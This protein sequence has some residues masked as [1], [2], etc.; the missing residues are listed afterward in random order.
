MVQFLNLKENKIVQY[1]LTAPSLLQQLFKNKLN[2]ERRIIKFMS[3]YL[4]WKP[5]VSEIN[6]T[7]STNLKFTQLVLSCTSCT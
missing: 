5:S 1:I 3:Q 4:S 7:I 6:S 2:F